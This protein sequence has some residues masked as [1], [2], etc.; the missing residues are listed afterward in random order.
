[1]TDSIIAFPG[2]WITADKFEQTLQRTFTFPL[3]DYSNVIFRLHPSCKVMVDAAVRLLSRAN[4]LVARGQEVAF[5][6]AGE[7]NDAM[8]YLNRANFFSCLDRRVEVMPERPNPFYAQL[9]LGNSKNLVEFKSISP[10][11]PEASSPIPRQLTDALEAA[12]EARADRKQLCHMAY[13][14]FGELI[15][16]VY[17]HSQTAL[18]SFAALQV[19]PSGGT[20]QV[21]VSDSGIGLLETLRPKLYSPTDK[22]MTDA[23]LIHSLFRGV[24]SW[25]DQG[26]GAGLKHCAQLALRHQSKVSIRLA[27]C[28]VSLRPSLEGYNV[29]NV[30]YQQDLP[31]LSG[32]HISFSF[33]LDIPT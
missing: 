12:T 21:V 18:D 2:S 14:L 3:P 28:Q 32:T 31:V 8:S 4:Q 10:T 11:D 33:P 22:T 5:V 19:Y 23:Q 1:M 6:F 16:N 20:A 30:Q 25:D 13:T 27:T 15:D 29:V 9:Y 24:V 26:R 7:Q 17:S